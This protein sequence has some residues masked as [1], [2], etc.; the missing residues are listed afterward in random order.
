MSRTLYLWLRSVHE[1]LRSFIFAHHR[2][3]PARMC[4][5][6]EAQVCSPQFPNN[7]SHPNGPKYNPS[8][9]RAQCHQVLCTGKHKDRARYQWPNKFFLFPSFHTSRI[10]RFPSLSNI[11]LFRPAATPP[12]LH[13]LQPLDRTLQVRRRCRAPWAPC[14]SRKNQSSS[15][16]TWPPIRRNE[17]PPSLSQN[18]IALHSRQT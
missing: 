8:H 5:S 14:C 16:Q 17:G 1:V 9:H 13:S 11:I 15:R 10:R 7:Q 3:F 12:W 2:I 6:C 4:L 18:N